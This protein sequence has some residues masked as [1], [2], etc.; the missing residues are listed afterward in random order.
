MTRPPATADTRPRFLLAGATGNVVHVATCRLVRR[1]RITVP[2]T[3]NGPTSGD[4]AKQI[5]S[6]DLQACPDCKPIKRLA[7]WERFG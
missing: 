4:L 2:F 1:A 6:S 7:G 5:G 3:P